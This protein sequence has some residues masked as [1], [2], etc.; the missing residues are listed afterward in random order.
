M[1]GVVGIINSFFFQK[2]RGYETVWYAGKTRN[3]FHQPL[4]LVQPYKLKRRKNTLLAVKGLKVYP[5]HT[6]PVK[7]CL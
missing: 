6:S 4:P 3:R 2:P 1:V 5:S 7:R